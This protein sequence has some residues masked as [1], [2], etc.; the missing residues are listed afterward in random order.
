M[1]LRR[2]ARR[3]KGIGLPCDATA[4]HCCGST[5]KALIS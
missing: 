2:R 3:G 1:A 4:K 5:A